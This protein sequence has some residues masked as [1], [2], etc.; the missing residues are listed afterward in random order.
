MCKK[1]VILTL[2]CQYIFINKPHC[3]QPEK[4]LNKII[5]TRNEYK[6]Y[7]PSSQTKSQPFNVFSKVYSMLTT[8]FSTVCH[9]VYMPYK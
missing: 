2:P 6:K 7:A 3:K 8:K 1:F 4:V 9:L 5:C